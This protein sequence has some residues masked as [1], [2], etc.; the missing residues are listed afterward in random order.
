MS[1]VR[2]NGTDAGIKQFLKGVW[3]PKNA[4]PTLPAGII[5]YVWPLWGF[6]QSSGGG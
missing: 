4:E 6:R 2:V 1:G 3:K 5:I